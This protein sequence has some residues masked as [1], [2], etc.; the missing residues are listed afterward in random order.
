[1]LKL[2][3][4]ADYGLI[5]LKHLAM[6]SHPDD[7]AWSE[8]ANAREIAD[9]YGI[10][11]PLLSKILQKLARAG[12]L[13][14]E[15][16]TNGGYRLARDPRLISALEVIRTIDGPI[17]LTACFTEHGGRECHH[18]EKCIVREPLR[19]VHEGILNMLDRITISDM[20]S[21]DMAVPQDVHASA[22][23][24]GLEPAAAAARKES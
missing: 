4:K 9:T 14:S 8:T 11:L 1:M 23:L 21:D 6:R 3:K 15:H 10:P 7:G 24:Y 2:T 12:F 17:I 20:S 18:T 19:K 16:G 22:R 13:Q 5:A